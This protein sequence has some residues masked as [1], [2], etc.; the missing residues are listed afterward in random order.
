MPGP[1]SSKRLSLRGARSCSS[2][3]MA[4]HGCP[5]CIT[6]ARGGLWRRTVLHN[7]VRRTLEFEGAGTRASHRQ[8]RGPDGSPVARRR[9]HGGRGV[10]QPRNSDPALC[11]TAVTRQFGNPVIQPA[12]KLPSVE[13]LARLQLQSEPIRTGSNMYGHVN[14]VGGN[15]HPGGR[16]AG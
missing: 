13:K 12:G 7:E 8:S 14:F 11:I 4:V 16:A 10:P 15:R 3:R 6:L 1:T 5:H 9:H 2:E